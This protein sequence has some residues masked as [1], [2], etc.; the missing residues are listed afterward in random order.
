MSEGFPGRC[1]LSMPPACMMEEN[2]SESGGWVPGWL[3]KVPLPQACVPF[4][5]LDR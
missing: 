5:V 2:Q 1:A 4:T 3:E